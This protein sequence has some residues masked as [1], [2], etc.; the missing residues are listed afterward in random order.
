MLLLMTPQWIS[1][2]SSK[3]LVKEERLYN[4]LIQ[5]AHGDEHDRLFTIWS[6]ILQEIALRAGEICVP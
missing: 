4:K 1:D 3:E 6:Y 5:N 2:L